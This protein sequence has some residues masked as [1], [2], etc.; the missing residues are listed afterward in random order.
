MTAEQQRT[1][2][3]TKLENLRADRGWTQTELARRASQFA[4]KP[5]TRDRISKYAGGNSLPGA[6]HLAAIAKAL[7]VDK[8]ELLPSRVVRNTAHHPLRAT[9][10]EDG[11]A[12]LNINMMVPWDLAVEIVAMIRK[13]TGSDN[14]AA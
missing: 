8:A 4:E 13:A 12:Q 1:L 5:I 10:L 11:M 3:A 7:G 2:F 14:A 9:L 6:P